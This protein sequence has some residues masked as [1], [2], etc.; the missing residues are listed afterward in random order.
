MNTKKQEQPTS[1][2]LAAL[3]GCMLLLAGSAGAH[4]AV[5]PGEN[6]RHS[7]VLTYSLDGKLQ[8]TIKKIRSLVS[9]F[10]D[11][12]KA[13]RLDQS[14]VIQYIPV[15]RSTDSGYTSVF[16][17]KVRHVKNREIRSWFLRV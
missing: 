2:F 15:C 14:P 9:F 13:T 4:Q 5:T 7:D 1:H 3:T 6:V 16:S 8:H 10:L 11:K 12:D 17:N